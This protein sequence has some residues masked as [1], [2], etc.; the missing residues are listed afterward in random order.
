MPLDTSTYSDPVHGDVEF[1]DLRSSQ[2]STIAQPRDIVLM[3][4]LPK[5]DA[6][7]VIEDIVADIRINQTGTEIGTRQR[8][9]W[10]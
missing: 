9:L 2:H 8:M 10:R 1:S 3:S 6:K 5:R 4:K 7:R